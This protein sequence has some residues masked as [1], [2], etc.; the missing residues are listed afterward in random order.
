M[1]STTMVNGPL[2]PE[3]DALPPVAGRETR[4]ALLMVAPALLG[5][6]IFVLIPF[7]MAGWLSLHNIRLNSGQP[8]KWFGLEQYRRILLDSTFRG[9][10]YRALI[11]QRS[12]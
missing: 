11:S 4:A 2:E 12:V 5:L 9:D 3:V 10:F 7:L 6:A 8:A 1:S